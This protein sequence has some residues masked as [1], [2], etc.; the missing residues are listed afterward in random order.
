MSEPWTEEQSKC[1]GTVVKQPDGSLLCPACGRKW[2]PIV[3]EKKLAKQA[4]AKAAAIP[5]EAVEWI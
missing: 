5:V 4:T 3:N 2:P 1:T